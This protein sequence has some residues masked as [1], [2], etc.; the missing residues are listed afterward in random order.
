MACGLPD[1]SKL[2][3][4]HY[5]ALAA[6]IVL[7][8]ILLK[9]PDRASSNLK[10]AIGSLFLPL[11]GL[12]SSG[13]E[14]ANRGSLAVLP[15][16]EL[17]RQL[18]QV[19]SE[20][21]ALR[22]R[23]AQ[24]DEILRE[25]DRLRSQLSFPRIHSDWKL[26]LARIIGREP[27]N[28][29]R[30]MRIDLGSRDGVATNAPVLTVD[31]LVGRVSEVTYTQSQVVLLGDPDCRVSV[32]IRDTGDNGVIAPASSSPLD[33]ALVDIL[34]LSR[35]SKIQPG[36]T[37]ITSGLGGVFPKG[38]VVGQIADWRSVDF[39]LYREARVALAVKLNNLE[40]VWV[41]LP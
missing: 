33:S 16:A 11:I 23:E 27:A 12:E 34:Y 29:W 31:G 30:T 14:L 9:L 22:L 36:Q 3:R 6:I 24:R 18:E 13:R 8:V 21:E 1:E 40:E 38:I 15:R 41:K 2:K 10:R 20:N 37:V 39:G 28:W 5:I 7:T 19:R 26:R 25:N 17:I 4:T 35:A 32:L